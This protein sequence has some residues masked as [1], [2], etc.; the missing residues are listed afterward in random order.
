[1]ARLPESLSTR[2]TSILS[3]GLR[4]QQLLLTSCIGIGVGTLPL[5]WGSSLLCLLIAKRL[6]LNHL[7]LQSLNYLLYPL[8]LSLLLPFCSLGMRL[9][10]WGPALPADGLFSLLHRHADNRLLLLLLLNLKALGAWLCA[11]PPLLVLGYLLATASRGARWN[12]ASL[13]ELP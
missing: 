11:V 12:R 5:L 9:F 2:L 7:V 8:Q 3:S 10:P 1:L 4:P 6:Q 13:P